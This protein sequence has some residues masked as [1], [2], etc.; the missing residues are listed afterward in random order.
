M[1]NELSTSNNYCEIKQTK[2]D[3]FLALCNPFYRV[4][5]E[6]GGVDD[7]LV[8]VSKDYVFYM[9]TKFTLRQKF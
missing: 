2:N 1:M 5:H 7:S 9:P 4:S 3:P 6:Q 8:N